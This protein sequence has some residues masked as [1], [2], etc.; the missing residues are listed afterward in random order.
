MSSTAEIFERLRAAT[1]PAECVELCEQALLQIRR[2]DDPIAWGNLQGGLAASLAQT[3][4]RQ[5]TQVTFDKVLSGYHAALSVFTP[6][7][8]PELWAA[9]LINIGHTHMDAA[10]NGL[11]D[12]QSYIEAAISVFTQ[13]ATTPCEIGSD[14]RMDANYNL[15]ATLRIAASWRGISALEDSAS[16]YHRILQNLTEETAPEFQAS[17]NLEYAE[18]LAAIGSADA[19]GEAINALE[20]ALDV[21]TREADTVQWA[22]AQLMLGELFPTLP[23]G[24][25]AHHL[26]RATA[27][28]DAALEVFTA[29][30]FPDEWLRAHYQRGFV[31]VRR[32][33]GH[34]DENLQRAL[35]SQ[36][37]A[38]AA[39]PRD[40][41]PAI[42]APLQV[43]RAQTLLEY[44]DGDRQE[45]I[46]DAIIALEGAL[47]LLGDEAL[48]WWISAT[49]SLAVAYLE[50]EAGDGGENIERGIAALES[51]RSRDAPPADLDSWT[52]AQSNLGQA[53]AR[54]RRGEP[55]QNR[56]KAVAAL[57]AAVSVP[58]DEVGPRQGWGSAL[59]WLTL[60]TIRDADDDFLSRPGG[61]VPEDY[62]S[63]DAR[64]SRALEAVS[65]EREGR[66][67]LALDPHWHVPFL[68]EEE[69]YPLQEKLMVFISTGKVPVR[70]AKER[71]ELET[72]RHSHVRNMVFHLK[73][74][75]S[76]AHRTRALFREIQDQGHPFVLY[77]RG[78]NNRI[79]RFDK[80]SQVRG[81]GNLEWFALTNLVAAVRPM[82][83]VLIANPVE[84]PAVDLLVSEKQDWEMGFR[85]ESDEEWEQHVRA[86]ISDATYI[87]MH[88][89]QMT[90]GVVAEIELLGELGRLADTFFEDVQ[91]ARKAVGR[92]DC[93]PLDARALTIIRA[94]QTP[95]TPPMT[96]PPVM[97]PWVE[98]ARR[99]VME[100]SANA[101]EALLHRLETADRPVLDDLM[102]DVLSSMISDAVLLER[103]RQVRDL[104]DR[105]AALFGQMGEGFQEAAQLAESCT[106]LAG[107]LD[108]D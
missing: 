108:G 22:N 35:E 107:E 51:A 62:Y 19:A 17:I 34:R 58:V 6:D 4:G 28:L 103:D 96:L 55:K 67:P 102:L 47:P 2:D 29:D 5:F 87:V 14:T 13:A 101:V 10:R 64:F 92:A 69:T 46:E 81:T 44:S 56:A 53:Y 20:R 74:R 41:A 70:A 79:A 63:E 97:C 85:I 104:L 15:A 27:A 95:R 98:G 80:G 52:V 38:T 65:A 12:P 73:E 42:W 30:A 18:V 89:G 39:I 50:R 23:D 66:E 36:N 43:M 99:T 8:T 57:E 105:Q 9:T 77:L 16:G 54:R 31:L 88:N 94:H 91:A 93:Q 7:G 68:L 1:D 11:G 84:S 72:A 26:E 59:A 24:D 33:G 75:R 25:G 61:G 49:R 21:F 76:A 100:R 71:A 86:L 82:P 48:S 60:L 3:M 90:P 37:I 83:V 78:F 45:H 32:S 40:S 106:Q